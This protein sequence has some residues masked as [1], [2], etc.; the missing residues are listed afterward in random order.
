MTR[1]LPVRRQSQPD[2][3]L[4][5]VPELGNTSGDFAGLIGTDGFVELAPQATSFPAGHVAR[6]FPWA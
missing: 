1:F 5:A 2:G 6:F 3:R 4:A